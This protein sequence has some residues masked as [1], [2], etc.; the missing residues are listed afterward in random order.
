MKW[1][2]PNKKKIT[3][4]HQLGD[5]IFVKEKN[6]WKLKQYPKVNGAIVVLDPGSGDVKALVGG[7]NLNQANLIELLKPKDN[8]VQLSNLL[9][10]P[11][12]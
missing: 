6:I 2:I 10:T 11:L 8:Q 9:F 12:L 5:V 3:D 1:T 7:F 4:K